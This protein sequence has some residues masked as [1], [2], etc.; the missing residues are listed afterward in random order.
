MFPDGS[1]CP[2]KS[3]LQ[4]PL[5]LSFL[6]SPSSSNDLIPPHHMPSCTP[7]IYACSPSAP[8]G[9]QPQLR[10]FRAQMPGTPWEH[11]RDCVRQSIQTHI[12]E[13]C[14]FHLKYAL[15]NIFP[16]LVSIL[17]RWCSLKRNMPLKKCT[18]TFNEKEKKRI[19]RFLYLGM[20]NFCHSDLPKVCVCFKEFHRNLFLIFKTTFLY[21]I[22]KVITNSKLYYQY[23]KVY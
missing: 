5:P 14:W 18:Y 4:Q 6:K 17:V 22:L 13:C 11:K 15:K 12:H 2:S 3:K 9:P 20:A 19:K 16:C 10:V 1:F 21:N 23:Y 7:Q 8:W